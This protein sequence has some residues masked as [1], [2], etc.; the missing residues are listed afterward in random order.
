MTASFRPPPEVATSKSKSPKKKPQTVTGKATAPFVAIEDIPANNLLQYLAP[1][2][3]SEATGEKGDATATHGSNFKR[4]KRAPSGGKAACEKSSKTISA[5]LLPE[6]TLEKAQQ[7]DFLFGTSSQLA[8][9]E[10]PSF[11]QDLEQA[12]KESKSVN[13]PSEQDGDGLISLSS[14]SD[15]M[16]GS[17]LQIFT[18]PKNLWSVAARGVNGALQ[19]AEVI[20]LS[21]TP[22]VQAS[23]NEAF[24]EHHSNA[25]KACEKL[26]SAEKPSP[27]KSH[28][29]HVVTSSPKATGSEYDN[30]TLNAIQAGPGT[31]A[32]ISKSLAEASLRNRPQSRSP[33]RKAKG[34]IPKEQIAQVKES[35]MPNFQG[36]PA[37]D[38]SKE[39]KIKGFKP[40]KRRADQIALLERCW[41]S[42]K[43]RA[44][45]LPLSLDA[46]NLQP[47]AV[48]ASDFET[49]KTAASVKKRGRP[50]KAKSTNLTEKGDT[51]DG[52][53]SHHFKT[54]S[55]SKKVKGAAQLP[56]QVG[57]PIVPTKRNTTPP[58]EVFQDI[59]ATPRPAVSYRHPASPTAVE[60]SP[61]SSADATLT[62]IDHAFL[63][64]RITDAV[65][66]YPPTHD[67]KSLTWYEKMLMYDPIVLEDLTVWLNTEGLARIGVDDEIEPNVVKEWCESQSICCLW[68]ENLRGGTRARY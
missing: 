8:R 40:V 39:I 44:A 42:S 48:V 62:P 52:K 31:Q 10:S 12:I 64:Q 32:P 63:M 5:L 51:P 68:R 26:P 56:K 22:K 14:A 19:E 59:D 46:N 17:K 34:P 41:Q 7:Q 47:P 6:N 50:P 13:S 66:T 29:W 57:E 18:A 27:P 49:S 1:Q 11:L 35:G 33:T 58:A 38:L 45:L 20:D 67:M 30:A 60:Q 16:N 61:T 36:Y 54:K 43:D 15:S 37:A 4:K 24:A 21:I 9:D 2:A 53:E 25:A 23:R 55:R 3:K 28:D 65:M